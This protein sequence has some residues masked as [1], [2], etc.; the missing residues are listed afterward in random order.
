[1]CS[2][3]SIFSGITDI[4]EWFVETTDQEE[5]LGMWKNKNVR[6]VCALLSAYGLVSF[7]SNAIATDTEAAQEQKTIIV[8]PSKLE[9]IKLQYTTKYRPPSGWGHADVQSRKTK[10]GNYNNLEMVINGHTMQGNNMICQYASG[11]T[12]SHL[13]LAAIKKPIPSSMA[14]EPIS[15]NSF[16]CTPK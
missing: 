12:D 16:K 8:C 3:N 6:L 10:G 2:E 1:M 7:S 14:C 5:R 15:E 9:D 11:P 4:I 13:R